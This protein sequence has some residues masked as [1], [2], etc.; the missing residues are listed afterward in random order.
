MSAHAPDAAAAEP[1]APRRDWLS[2]MNRRRLENFRRNR[3]GHWSLWIFLILFVVTL[4]AEFIANDRP[5]VVSYRGELLFPAFNDYPEAKFGGFL[6]TTNFRDPFI[7]DEIAA[8][9]WAIWPPVRFSYDTVDGTLPYSGA[10]APS[11]TMDRAEICQNFPMGVEDVDCHWGNFHWLGTD[12]RGR[13]V[14]ARL[15]YGFRLSILFGLVLTIASSVIGVAA[16]A[17][18]GYFGGWTDLLFQRFIEIWTSIPALYLLL[19][20]SSVIAPSFWVL[21]GI[22]LLFS[23]V[24]LVGIVRAEFLRGRNFEYIA[25]ARA[26]GVSNAKIMWRH[27]LPNAMVATLT[28]MPFIMSGSVATLTSLD[29][30][31]F[32]L[33]P[34]SPS[35]GEL[36]AQ[37]KNNLQA[38]WLGL[39]GFFTIA[40][41]MTLLVFIGEAVRDAFD[42]R[43]T[44]A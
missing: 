14:L 37:G 5:I 16:G 8:N 30:L 18:Q 44:L 28:F 17:V 35:L 1:A 36:L 4:G 31:G 25:A 39:T 32:G 12:D 23:W 9:G 29:F 41:M 3:R 6:A 20:I 43:K 2:P 24:A 34:G 22:L 27:L 11:W 33:P 19:I 42:P 15:I 21:L 40:I 13:D 38:P 7:A 10:V 26:L